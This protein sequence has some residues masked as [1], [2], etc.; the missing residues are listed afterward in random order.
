MELWKWELWS[1]TAKLFVIYRL[2]KALNQNNMNGFY[3]IW[4]EF[5]FLANTKKS[6]KNESWFKGSTPPTGKNT[7]LLL[8]T[9]N[10]TLSFIPSTKNFLS[11][12]GFIALQSGFPA[13]SCLSQKM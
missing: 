4:D 3:M 12:E 1:E 10:E 6:P 2:L 5:C 11:S 9:L 13:N 7:P 8:L